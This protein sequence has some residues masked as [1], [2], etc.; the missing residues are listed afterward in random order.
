MEGTPKKSGNLSSE[1]NIS[2]PHS[3]PVQVLLLRHAQGTPL[4]P[5]RSHRTQ[6]MMIVIVLMIIASYTYDDDFHHICIPYA[7]M[8]VKNGPK[9]SQIEAARLE[10][11][12]PFPSGQPDS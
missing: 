4:H 5:Q 11:S 12:D 7:C 1:A 2:Q 8:Y 3:M 9:L 6:M 10:G